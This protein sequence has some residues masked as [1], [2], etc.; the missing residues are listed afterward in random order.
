MSRRISK[1]EG[2]E[3]YNHLLECRELEK[4]G[5]KPKSN[6]AEKKRIRRMKKAESFTDMLKRRAG[7][8]EQK[9]SE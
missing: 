4:Q 7:F 1:K 6:R 3:K 2:Q 5:I 9:E 8:H